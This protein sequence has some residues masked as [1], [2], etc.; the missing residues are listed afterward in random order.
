MKLI[1]IGL[2]RMESEKDGET[3]LQTTS[4][5]YEAILNKDLLKKIEIDP[6]TLE[7]GKA[8]VDRMSVDIVA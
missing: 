4:T 7:V 6:K 3:M 8:L 1:V 2:Q 5:S